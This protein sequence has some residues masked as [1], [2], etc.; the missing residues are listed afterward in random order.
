MATSEPSSRKGEAVRIVKGKYIKN[1][2][3]WLD[4]AF[5]KNMFTP[6]KVHIL[7]VKMDKEPPTPVFIRRSSIV[8]NSEYVAPTSYEEAILDQHPTIDQQMNS[9]ARSLARCNLSMDIDKQKIF[10]ILEMKMEEFEKEIGIRTEF[11]TAE[12]NE[13]RRRKLA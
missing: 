5:G 7:V 1:Y 8:R 10:K 12:N 2:G 9:L 3:A 13:K 11:G 6:K 4:T